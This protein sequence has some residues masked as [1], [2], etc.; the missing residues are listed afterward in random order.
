MKRNDVVEE[1]EARL[2][3]PEFETELLA[4]AQCWEA[5]QE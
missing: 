1:E 5:V 4:Q 2:C 3:V